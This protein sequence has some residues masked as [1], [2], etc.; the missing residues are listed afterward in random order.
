MAKNV[1]KGMELCELAAK[2]PD[3]NRLMKLTE[4]I[5]RLLDEKREHQ[6]NPGTHGQWSRDSRSVKCE[7][8]RR[9]DRAISKVNVVDRPLQA[10]AWR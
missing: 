2:E 6:Q 9:P 10:Q 1:E 5:V 3:P 4:E 8:S 7:T